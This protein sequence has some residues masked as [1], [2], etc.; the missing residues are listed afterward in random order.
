M[1]ERKEIREGRRTCRKEA[2]VGRRSAEGYIKEKNRKEVRRRKR[3]SG[4]G[5]MRV[6]R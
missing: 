4:Q 3:K 2:L 1:E 5:L 6:G